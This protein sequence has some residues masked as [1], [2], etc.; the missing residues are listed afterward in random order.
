L[1]DRAGFIP[2]LPLLIALIVC[3]Y[4]PNERANCLLSNPRF[5]SSRLKTA[6]GNTP[7]IFDISGNIVFKTFCKSNKLFENKQIC[8]LSFQHQNAT[9]FCK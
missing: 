9:L 6:Q 3:G 8:L 4:S 5:F 7:F 1:I 2:R